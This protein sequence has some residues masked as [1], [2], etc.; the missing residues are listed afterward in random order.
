MAAGILFISRTPGYATDLMSY[1]FGNILLV[2]ERELWIM[3]GLDA[4]LLLIVVLFYR[5]FLAVAFD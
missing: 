1:L 3:A 4:G 5:Q 2:P